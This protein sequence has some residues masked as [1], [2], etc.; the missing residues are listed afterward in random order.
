MIMNGL[1]LLV[2]KKK[3]NDKKPEE[4]KTPQDNTAK[5]EEG[6]TPQTIPKAI[7]KNISDNKLPCKSFI[8]GKCKATEDKPCKKSHTNCLSIQACKCCKFDT[9][10]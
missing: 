3:A 7:I 2:E 6:K 10:G 9:L 5:P 4:E 1:P 8:F